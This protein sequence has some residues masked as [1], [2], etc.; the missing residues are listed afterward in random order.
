MASSRPIEPPAPAPDMVTA[1][2]RHLNSQYSRGVDRLL[3]DLDKRPMPDTQAVQAV[4]T[5]SRP[6]ERCDALD[7]GAALVLVQ[8]VRL[9]LDCLES[10]VFTVAQEI[11]LDDDSLAAVLE[12][13]DAGAAAA[14]RTY[15]STRRDLPRSVIPEHNG[16]SDGSQAAAA[17]AGQR[18]RQAADRAAKAAH[19]REELRQGTQPV[20]SR[21]T[22]AEMAAAHAGAARAQ[23][24]EAAERVALGLLRAATALERCAV[25]ALEWDSASGSGPELRLRAEEYV[26]SARRYREMAARYR[27][28]GAG[29]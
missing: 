19:R 6:R 7:I 22:D 14:R 15:L 2:R 27:D 13:P 9:D 26:A 11:G 24:D 23:A 5:P 20:A 1:S 17:R 3:W 28:F 12:L 25:R 18:A 16:S 4:I 29:A 8:A 21:H 10:E